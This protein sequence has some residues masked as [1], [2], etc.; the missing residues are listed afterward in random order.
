M[1]RTVQ[2]NLRQSL[3]VLDLACAQEPEDV[4]GPLCHGVL[5]PVVMP[6]LFDTQLHAAHVLVTWTVVRSS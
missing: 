3:L 5:H 6:Q 2:S 4:L 1:F